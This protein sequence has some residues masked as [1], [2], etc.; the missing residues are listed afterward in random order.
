MSNYDP[1]A[2][3]YDILETEE[4]YGGF[5]REPFGDDSL[6]FVWVARKPT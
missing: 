3:D 4:L 1:F 5:D 2:A 6:E